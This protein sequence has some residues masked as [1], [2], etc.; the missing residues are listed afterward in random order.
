M[1]RATGS[2]VIE[3]KPSDLGAGD[4]TW[5]RCRSSMCEKRRGIRTSGD[6]LKEVGRHPKLEAGNRTRSSGRA[7]RDSNHCAI[8]PPL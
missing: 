8:A 1:V 4:R 7:S 6:E 3:W 2:G 5:A